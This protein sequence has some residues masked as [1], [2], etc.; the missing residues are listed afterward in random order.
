MTTEKKGDFRACFCMLQR[1][2]FPFNSPLSN[3]I[4]IGLFLFFY[5]LDVVFPINLWDV[6]V[7][8]N[9]IS[10]WCSLSSSCMSNSICKEVRAQVS[11]S[12]LYLH[13]RNVKSLMKKIGFSFNQEKYIAQETLI[14]W[15]ILSRLARVTCNFAP[16][17]IFMAVN[18]CYVLLQQAIRNNLWKQFTICTL[19]IYCRI[20][21]F[22]RENVKFCHW[23]S[24]LPVHNLYHYIHKIY[25]IF[26]FLSTHFSSSSK[27]T[28]PRC[29]KIW[30]AD[31]LVT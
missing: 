14:Y 23:K 11:V 17:Y 10:V 1:D 7:F 12:V 24:T 4:G 18:I 20:L 5:D 27:I 31:W 2:F 9:E 30:R 28:F 19:S 25:Q 21:R 15:L 22:K 3:L 8:C 6:L 13:K 29:D 26:L 16:F